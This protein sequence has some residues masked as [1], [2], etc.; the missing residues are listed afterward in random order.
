MH[1]DAIFVVFHSHRERNSD[2]STVRWLNWQRCCYSWVMC[3]RSIPGA[4]SSNYG[5]CE[6]V[7]HRRSNFCIR[8]R[9]SYNNHDRSLC[10]CSVQFGDWR[11]YKLAEIVE[12][13]YWRVCGCFAEGE[14]NIQID[15]SYLLMISVVWMVYEAWVGCGYTVCFDWRRIAMKGT[16]M[17]DSQKAVFKYRYKI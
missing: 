8:Y 12:V 7:R 14:G 10:V 15:C 6:L 11:V 16:M 5:G 17:S 13:D 1:W 9:L 4:R 3:E 2:K